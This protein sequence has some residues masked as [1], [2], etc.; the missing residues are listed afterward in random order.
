MSFNRFKI[1]LITTFLLFI[2]LFIGLAHAEIINQIAPDFELP[3]K[4][5][6]VRLSDNKGKVVYLDFWA[7]WCGPCKQSFPWMN[8]MQE[9]YKNK[10]F[11]IIA[12]NLDANNEDAQKFLISTLAKFTVAFDSKGQTPL[13]YGVKGMPTSYLIDRDG[14]I[15]MQ[16][17]GFNASDREKLEQKIQNLLVEKK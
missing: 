1:A 10:G 12:V 4:P 6:A 15:V 17:M 2:T 8:A 11:E 5:T 9:K 3:G 16:H 7:S 13:Q 14:K